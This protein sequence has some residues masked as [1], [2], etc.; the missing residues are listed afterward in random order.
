MGVGGYGTS[1]ERRIELYFQFCIALNIVVVVVVI[2]M[3]YYKCLCSQELLLGY[4][5]FLLGNH[6]RV[7]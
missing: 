5:N 7:H 2:L 4:V 1:S 6:T 3:N